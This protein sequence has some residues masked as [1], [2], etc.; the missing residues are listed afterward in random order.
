MEHQDWKPVII[1][2]NKTKS[3]DEAKR[4]GTIQTVH[5]DHRDQHLK[6]IDKEDEVQHIEKVDHNV[7]III[8]KARMDKKWTQ[9]DLAQ[10]INVKFEMIRDMEAGKANEDK[11]LLSKLQRPLGVKLLGKNIGDKY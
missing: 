4:D 9:K 6:K 10:K 8:Q 2:R 7:S 11:G 5:K 1:G 3:K